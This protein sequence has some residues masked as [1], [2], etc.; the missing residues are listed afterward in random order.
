MGLLAAGGGAS[1][2][3]TRLWVDAI[4]SAVGGIVIMA[5]C[6]RWLVRGWAL[7]A[8]PEPSDKFPAELVLVP[9]ALFMFIHGG[10][11][12]IL[13]SRLAEGVV[14]QVASAIAAVVVTAAILLI[15]AR[16]RPGGVRGLL[17]GWTTPSRHL[18]LGIAGFS[19]SIPLC[20]GAVEIS[21]RMIGL[22]DPDAELPAHQVLDM[23]GTGDGPVWLPVLL[24]VNAVVAAP[25]VEEMF[26]RGMCQP[27]FKHAIGHRG[28]AILLTALI[29]GAVH[30][31][32]PQAVVP[33][34]LLGGILGWLYERSG[35]LL[36][37]MTMH[38]C[39]NLKTMILFTCL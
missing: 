24:W 32:Q 2:V 38:V 17:C 27:A 34:I 37:S 14:A 15:N 20:W 13:E 30:A 39:F 21:S 18:L 29:F 33:M 11:A 26:F 12:L 10:V 16:E 5:T 6:R 22:F 4:L 3:D 7:P 25:V 9:L 8:A 23:L 19:A 31:S 28:W 35:G 1:S 36:A